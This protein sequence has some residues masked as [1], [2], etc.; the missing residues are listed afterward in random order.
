M[1]NK[2]CALQLSKETG[3]GWAKVKREMANSSQSYFQQV[4]SKICKAISILLFFRILV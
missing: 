4:V 2:Y 1:P 3:G